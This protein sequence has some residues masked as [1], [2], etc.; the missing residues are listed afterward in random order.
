MNYQLHYNRLVERA[1]NR[2][3]AGYSERHHVVPRCLDKSSTYV[4]KLTPEEHYVAHQLLCKMN[5]GNWKLVFAA[6]KM[7]HIGNTRRTN[8]RMYGWLRRAWNASASDAAKVGWDNWRASA[9]PGE[10]TRV[11]REAAIAHH[12]AA[13]RGRDAKLAR[14]SNVY[15]WTI[16]EH[17][18]CA[19]AQ[20]RHD[21]LAIRNRSESMR[22]KVSAAKILFYANNPD[23]SKPLAERNKQKVW[24]EIARAK[25]SVAH[26]GQVHSAESCAR[27]A[28]SLK[29]TNARK[30]AADALLSP[31]LKARKEIM[32]LQKLIADLK[33]KEEKENTG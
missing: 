4:V 12:V 33:A 5:P 25:N 10:I 16:L 6:V 23:A 15:F 32:R 3:L 28:A 24:D 21:A 8:N 13:G 19:E 30:K 26:I 17:I 14:V 22:A 18:A 9:E 20:R 11:R 2:V 27:Q 29:A 1:K 7:T 31:E